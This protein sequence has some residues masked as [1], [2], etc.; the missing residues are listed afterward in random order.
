MEFR[1]S[2]HAKEEMVR[3][4]ISEQHL[5]TVMNTPP[6]QIVSTRGDLKAYQSIVDFG[7]GKMFLIR[8]IVND[9]V[10]PAVVVTVY[11]TSKIAK[12]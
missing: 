9:N 1:V 7:N 10:E 5:I 6:Q 3:R 11:I 4:S 2:N 8:V 12:Y